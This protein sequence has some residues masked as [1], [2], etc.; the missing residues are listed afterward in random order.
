MR[1]AMRSAPRT[2]EELEADPNGRW[3]LGRVHL[4]V[5]QPAQQLGLEKPARVLFH[6]DLHNFAELT[7][8]LPDDQ[9]PPDTAPALVAALYA[10]EGTAFLS[11]LQGSFCLAILD[12]GR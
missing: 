6:G 4:G 2:T 7:R 10:A 9:R 11:R 12:G 5:L 1:G 8:L 3:A